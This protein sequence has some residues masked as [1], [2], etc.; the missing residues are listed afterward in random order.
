MKLYNQETELTANIVSIEERGGAFI[1]IV[2]TMADMHG[3]THAD[4]GKGVFKVT[5]LVARPAPS[6]NWTLSFA[7][8]MSIKEL[9]DEMVGT[10][11]KTGEDKFVETMQDMGAEVVEI[12]KPKRKKISRSTKK[13]TT[14]KKSS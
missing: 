3:V 13:S 2:E 12:P 4:A 5:N 14:R 11:D 8:E 7:R 9:A 6:K 1:V 10:P